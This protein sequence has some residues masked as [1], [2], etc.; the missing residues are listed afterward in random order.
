MN[1]TLLYIFHLSISIK[2][3]FAFKNFFN[4]ERKNQRMMHIKGAQS[5]FYMP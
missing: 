4:F 5:L 3:V 2:I 1:K